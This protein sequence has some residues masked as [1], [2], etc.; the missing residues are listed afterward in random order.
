MRLKH[1]FLGITLIALSACIQTNEQSGRILPQE[2][3]LSLAPLPDGA[4]DKSRFVSIFTDVCLES[5]LDRRGFDRTAKSLGLSRETDLK[6][7][8]YWHPREESPDSFDAVWMTRASHA[9]EAMLEMALRYRSSFR[10]EAGSPSYIVDYEDGDPTMILSCTVAA[11]M[12]SLTEEE[13]ADLEAQAANNL[14]TTA[15]QKTFG[16]YSEGYTVTP[17]DVDINIELSKTIT[18]VDMREGSACPAGIGCWA[19]SPYK[20]TLTAVTNRFSDYKN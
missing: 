1:V 5:S 10:W 8:S 19:H 11:I 15:R 7:I 3:R 4:I 6:N 20:I 13:T 17:N 18:Y 14:L 9:S 12:P 2:A 16:G